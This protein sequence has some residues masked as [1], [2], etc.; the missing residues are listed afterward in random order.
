MLKAPSLSPNAWTVVMQWMQEHAAASASSVDVATYKCTSHSASDRVNPSV[1]TH[2]VHF[3]N[4]NEET[5]LSD[6]HLRS[7]TH[8]FGDAK[9][10]IKTG[11][12][13]DR[14]RSHEF[15]WGLVFLLLVLRKGR[16]INSGRRGKQSLNCQ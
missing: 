8:I 6:D 3:R 13:P 11:K 15:R 7:L 12:P 1:T 9:I 14:I 10:N 16:A 4:Q 5:P 2:V